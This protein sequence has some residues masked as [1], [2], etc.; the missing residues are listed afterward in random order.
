[1]CSLLL[2]SII[3]ES[4]EQKT[5]RKLSLPPSFNVTGVFMKN[6]D[7]RD[8]TGTCTVEKDYNDARWVC[9]KLN[10]PLI[11]VDFVKEYWNEV[12]S[13]VVEKYQNGYTPNPDILCNR[14][15]KFDK[16]F[17]LARN[18]L[19]ADAI[20][21]GHYAKTSF[22]PYLE[23]Y[24][25]DTNARLLQAQDSNKDQTF[26]LSQIP[27]RTLRRC[28]FPL[29]DYLKSHVKAM[30][31]QVGLHKIARKKESMG[32]CFVGK[33]CTRSIWRLCRFG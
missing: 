11:Q 24:K 23:N 25:A 27:Q 8:E 28:M 5:P 13:D 32:I 9:D 15:I 14:N 21:T 10:I 17:H 29:G 7:I 18:R 26:F 1:M 4:V 31:A 16:F 12:F 33:L 20:A 2:I 19:E 6:W 22:G 3:N 30:A